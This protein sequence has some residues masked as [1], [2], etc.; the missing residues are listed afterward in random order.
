MQFY[1][2]ISVKSR[3][4]GLQNFSIIMQGGISDFHIPFDNFIAFWNLDFW[5][6]THTFEC[7]RWLRFFPVTVGPV[8]ITQLIYS[9]SNHS[10]HECQK[11]HGWVTVGLF[12][13]GDQCL[14]YCLATSRSFGFTCG[15]FYRDTIQCPKKEKGQFTIFQIIEHHTL[16]K[17]VTALKLM[18]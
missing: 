13:A 2:L 12:N 7:T 6:V 3:E 5:Q 9:T 10:I 4:V 18:K 11:I 16:L 8:V 15:N 14:T 1:L 17:H